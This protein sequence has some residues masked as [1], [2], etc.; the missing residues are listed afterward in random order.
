MH[1][2]IDQNDRK[3]NSR[4]RR[5][6]LSGTQAGSPKLSRRRETSAIGVL[7]PKRGAD[8][9]GDA[10]VPWKAFHFWVAFASTARLSETAN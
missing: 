6:R 2:L 5:Y 1:C 4:S 3:F 9:L 10:S 7:L 8:A